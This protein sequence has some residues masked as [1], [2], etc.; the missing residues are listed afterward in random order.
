TFPPVSKADTRPTVVDNLSEPGGLVTDQFAVDEQTNPVTVVRSVHPVKFV[1]VQNLGTAEDRLAAA[2]GVV[3]QGELRLALARRQS[4]TGQ[5]LFRLEDTTDNSLCAFRIRDRKPDRDGE[6]PLRHL[7]PL[8]AVVPGIGETIRFAI[9]IE[10]F[11][12][13]DGDGL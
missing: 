10:P 3:R 11:L 5:S 9:E 7:R 6:I 12:S 13:L 1:R 8:L 4:P 2:G